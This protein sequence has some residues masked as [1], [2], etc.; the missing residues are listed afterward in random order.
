MHE[1]GHTYLVLCDNPK[2]RGGEGGGGG[3]RM[4]GHVHIYGGFT[5]M[6]GKK[7]HNIIIILQLK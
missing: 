7:H 6:C 1:A 4:G 2:G 3:L 5:L